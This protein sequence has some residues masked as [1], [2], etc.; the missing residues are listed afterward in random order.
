M[1]EDTLRKIIREETNDLRGG[2]MVA[3]DEGRSHYGSLRGWSYA[4][5]SVIAPLAKTTIR[6]IRDLAYKNDP[7]NGPEEE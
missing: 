7:V 3:V 4:L 2:I 5:A 1:D 6:A